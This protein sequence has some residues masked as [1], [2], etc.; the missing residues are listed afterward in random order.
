MGKQSFPLVRLLPFASRSLA[1]GG[2]CASTY[3]RVASSC[4]ASP[5]DYYHRVKMVQKPIGNA[6]RY[7]VPKT[8]VADL[9]A[10]PIMGK[11][12]KNFSGGSQLVPLRGLL[13]PLLSLEQCGEV[14]TSSLLG[15]RR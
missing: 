12:A 6:L 1:D 4:Q 13:I 9:F 8:S 15:A 5:S 11:K 3:P 14:E 7:S 2:I 10:L